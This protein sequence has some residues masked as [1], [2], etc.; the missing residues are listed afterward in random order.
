VSAVVEQIAVAGQEQSAGIEQINQ[1]VSQMD[2]V[3][4][5]NAALVEEAAAAAAALQDQAERLSSVVGVFK[6]EEGAS[7]TTALAPRASSV[8]RLTQQEVA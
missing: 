5:Q 1:A 7:P 3:T 4:Q 8:P 2:T 6:V